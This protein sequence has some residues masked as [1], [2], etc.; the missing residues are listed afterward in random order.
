MPD[1]KSLI[2]EIMEEIKQADNFD[3][4]EIDT[5][6]NFD[7]QSVLDSVDAILSENKKSAIVS[8][9]EET[10][11]K[12]TK[13]EPDANTVLFER[14]KNPDMDSPTMYFKRSRFQTKPIK[15]E[16][17]NEIVYDTVSNSRSKI[18]NEDNKSGDTVIRN[19][20]KQ[21]YEPVRSFKGQSVID[22][23][24]N[25]Q[26]SRM[27]FSQQIPN[28]RRISKP[29][30]TGDIYTTATITPEDRLSNTSTDD[31]AKIFGPTK[32]SSTLENA[33]EI[34]EGQI[35]LSGFDDEIVPDKVDDEFVAEQLRNTRLRKIN[36]FNAKKIFD[37]YEGEENEAEPSQLKQTDEIPVTEN[38]ENIEEKEPAENQEE[39]NLPP[40]KKGIHTT[41][42]ERYATRAV[43]V[44]ALLVA[45]IL[46]TV[47]FF[48]FPSDGSLALY[49]VLNTLIL[50][51]SS[52]FCSRALMVGV[53][54]VLR[55]K[56]TM[57]SSLAV[58]TLAVLIQNISFMACDL[59]LENAHPYQLGVILIML[60]HAWGKLSIEERIKNNF[61]NLSQMN[62]VYAISKIGDDEIASLLGK[63]IPEQNPSIVYSSKVKNISKFMQ[64]SDEDNEFKH[65]YG[66]FSLIMIIIALVIA[67]FA[68]IVS[69]KFV[70]AITVFSALTCCSI[71]AAAVF[72][73]NMPLLSFSKKG[74][75]DGVILGYGAV[76]Q[77]TDT[78]AVAID[79][80]S[81]FPS[82][83]CSLYGIKTFNN[84]P[85]DEA[86][87]LTTA[88]LV[89]AENPLGGVFSGII[90]GKT[91]ILP[92]VEECN[93]EDGLGISAWI[94]GKRVLVGSRD[95]MIH[96]GI[97]VLTPQNERKYIKNNRQI[98]YLSVENVLS[99][100]FVVSLMPDKKLIPYIK[101]LQD[102]DITILVRSTDPNLSENIL[103]HHF[104]AYEST[105]KILNGRC[106]EIY[107]IFSK[108]SH[109]KLAASIV[110]RNT[111]RSMF[112]TLSFSLR[113]RSMI[114][115]AFR[116]N[117]IGSVILFAVFAA[118]AL[119]DAD[120]LISVLNLLILQLIVT[121]LACI[122]PKF[123]KK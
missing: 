4:G 54:D 70:N 22:G 14:L 3:E 24:V 97:D 63:G 7:R 109:P 80:C 117:V 121:A 60:L 86:I 40:K 42:R 115:A 43:Q 65:K 29:G 5:Q 32:N 89:A 23:K 27:D 12:Y 44:I 106:G 9:I 47:L 85:I 79:S 26:R 76:N 84:M 123:I 88:A 122:I 37:V 51:V 120:I 119:I 33:P 19:V 11:S 82:E 112:K 104:G 92:Y 105:F 107:R 87:L 18:N 100:M 56:F 17:T 113:L 31:L 71:P 50:I 83:C 67:V 16:E 61:H 111:P 66:K 49:S 72:C 38:A 103:A 73:S 110:H 39:Q 48:F 2:D 25:N 74:R 75:K 68:F 1:E 78:N 118:S 90:E 108:A 116:V 13:D 62:D 41:L 45:A 34:V 98:L 52:V 10:V 94:D 114:R 8:D 28:P 91:A 81:L 53:T 35:R 20:E 77:G 21:S 36:E 69:G 64:T 101:R 58:A 96:R 59:S 15:F 6:L 93:Y 95:M 99:A 55:K 46:N 57:N 102:N 30:V